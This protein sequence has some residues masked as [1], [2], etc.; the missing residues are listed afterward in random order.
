MGSLGLVPGTVSLHPLVEVVSAPYSDYFSLGNEYT[1]REVPWNHTHI[2]FPTL[3]PTHF[4]DALSVRFEFQTF[5]EHPSPSSAE[6]NS[7]FQRSADEVSLKSGKTV[8]KWAR[9][10]D[11]ITEA[12]RTD[13]SSPCSQERNDLWALPPS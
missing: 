2:L 12:V 8:T 10:G 6:L 4:S 7:S 9:Q 1:L 3:L 13:H 5:S 11:T